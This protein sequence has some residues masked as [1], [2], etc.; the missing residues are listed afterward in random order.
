MSDGEDIKTILDSKLHKFKP[1]KH[2]M[3]YKLD[4]KIKK[5]CYAR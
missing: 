5:R 3:A 1:S 4:K 2:K